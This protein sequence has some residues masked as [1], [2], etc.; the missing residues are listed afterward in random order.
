MK[1][2]FIF[3]SLAVLALASCNKVV[4]T[5]DP[6]ILDGEYAGSVKVTVA[7][8]ICD[9]G[10]KAT[11]TTKGVFNW[12]DGDQI[13][14]WPMSVA[15][16]QVAQQHMFK[17]TDGGGTSATFSGSGWALR[18]GGSY[19]Y[20][21]YFP[22]DSTC[23]ENEVVLYYPTLLFQSGNANIEHVYPYLYMHANPIT[24][25]TADAC[26]FDFYQLGCI[27]QLNLTGLPSRVRDLRVSF[28]SPLIAT[29]CTYDPTDDTPTLT[30][31]SYV[32]NITIDC[33]G[34]NVNSSGEHRAYFIVAPSNVMGQTMTVT[35]QTGSGKYTQTYTCGANWEAGKLLSY[36]LPMV[37]NTDAPT[38]IKESVDLGTG[39]GI[40]WATMNVGASSI[41][42]PGY[43][44][45]WGG[46]IDRTAPTRAGSY[47]R[48]DNLITE[49]D[50]VQKIWGGNWRMPTRAE[51]D[52]LISL[53]TITDDCIDGIYGI[54]VSNNSD[55]S[56]YIF[57]PFGGHGGGNG[58]GSESTTSLFMWSST[59]S[60]DGSS[61]AYYFQKR[62]GT[63]AL[64][65]SQT[66][67][68]YFSIRPVLDN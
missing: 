56:K 6:Q 4:N 5:E 14:I 44:V 34:N 29:N 54:R 31:S 52:R 24:P 19:E 8:F 2:P 58:G 47:K 48:N 38:T 9:D 51:I 59:A 25:A 7:D 64:R 18:T 40:E 16:G 61:S 12:S 22:Y 46:L 60:A 33:L 53:C 50:I 65:S 13:G 10:T 41:T 30:P 57:I 28:D 32:S 49:D 21:A 26:S 37:L 36:N 55:P 27:L 62:M 15:P 20:S 11:V 39:D 17:T 23:E 68:Y 35:A 43:Y 45:D 1:K 67:G 42:D 3:A 63:D 66:P